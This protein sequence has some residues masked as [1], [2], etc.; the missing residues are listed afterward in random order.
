LLVTGAIADG[1]LWSYDL[2]GRP[3]IP[4]A[5]P[6]DN[7][8][9]VWSPDSRQVAFATIQGPAEL[10]TLPADGSVLAPQS[11]RDPLPGVPHVWSA[12]GEL[13]MTANPGDILATPATPEG[14]VRPVV[15][16]TEYAEFDPALS[17]NGRWLAYISNRTGTVEIWVQGYPDGVPVR[18]SRNGG[19]EP[20][21]SRD[22]RELFYWQGNAMMA[23]TVETED[24]FSF[25]AAVQL[26]TGR[27]FQFSGAATRTYDVA[28]DGRFLM[29][30]PGDEDTAAAPASIVVVQ[31]F[32]EELKDRVRATGP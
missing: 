18:V 23:V 26:F 30:L 4:L 27:F 17:P 20:Q 5:L 9:P 6:A 7:R 14:D 24:A 22:G 10:V 8:F 3:P 29:I 16:S 28:G 12:A 31:N 1:D 11:L 13:V 15:A 32:N 25:G 21:W 19:F 2:G